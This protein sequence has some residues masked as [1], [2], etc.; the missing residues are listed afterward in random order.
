[1]DDE[2]LL[3]SDPQYRQFK[4][5]AAACLLQFERAQEWADLIRYLLRLQKILG[6]YDTLPIIPDKVLFAKRL[7]QCLNPALPA[8]VHEE[9]LKTIEQIFARIGQH[10]LARGVHADGSRRRR[11]TRRRHPE[12]SRPSWARPVAD[13]AFYSE[14]IFPLYRHASYQVKPKLLDL[15]ERYYVPLGVRVVPCL[16]GLVLSLLSA[17]EDVGSEFYHRAVKLLDAL[18]ECTPIEAIMSAIWGRLLHNANVRYS[19][20]TYLTMRFPL[21]GAAGAFDLVP[22][23]GTPTPGE[24]KRAHVATPQ[25]PVHPVPMLNGHPG[26]RAQG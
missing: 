21:S 8:G 23:P 2:R 25:R 13:L 18:T 22:T 6:K 12:R 7:Y 17:M 3:S 11:R 20:L 5:E 15:F 14:G 10:R 4:D 9:T 26:P 16:P 24:R 19:A 1:M